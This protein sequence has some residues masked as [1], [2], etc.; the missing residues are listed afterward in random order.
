[1]ESEAV[2]SVA[3]NESDNVLMKFECLLRD[4]G[5][6]YAG[7]YTLPEP[8]RLRNNDPTEDSSSTGAFPDNR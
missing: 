4:A 3:I 2:K 8:P 6:H 5:Q 7:W 1:M